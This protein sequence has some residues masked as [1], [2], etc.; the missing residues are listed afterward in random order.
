MYRNGAWYVDWNGNNQWDAEDAAHVFYFGLPGDLPV[1]GD[2][3]SIQQS[4]ASLQAA[5]TASPLEMALTMQ[6]STD[7]RTAVEKM[8]WDRN[9]M[10]LDPD[11]RQ[12]L[13]DMQWDV[14]EIESRH[15][16]QEHLRRMRIDMERI[17]EQQPLRK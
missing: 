7:L 13:S 4:A 17:R 16:V 10:L 5:T 11:V 6:Q 1:M 2:W 14:A 15:E 9:A 8:E 12:H 3:K